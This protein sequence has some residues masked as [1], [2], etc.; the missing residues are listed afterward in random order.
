VEAR[1]LIS[2]IA[3][4][5]GL[6]TDEVQ[7]RLSRGVEQAELRRPDK[8]PAQRFQLIPFGDLKPSSEPAYLIKGLFPRVGLVVV[9]GP[10][11]RGKSFW[12][13]TTMLY[14]ALGW[15]YRGH[16]VFQGAVVYCAF[17]GQDGYG[18]R[19]EA[20][21]QRHLAEAA[22]P[23]P[24]YL[25]AAR[26]SLV[27][28][29]PALISAIKAEAISPAVVVLDTLNRS[30]DGSESDDKDMANYIKAADAI[31][32][33]LGCV[34]VIVHHS[35]V[36][37]TRPRG[38]T[39][40]TGAVDAQIKVMR[41]AAGNIV[42]EVEWMKD[43]PEGEIIV[44]RLEVVDVGTDADGEPI[45]SCVVAPVDGQA[46]PEPARPNKWSKSPLFKALVATI[47]DGRRVQ[48]FGAEGPS[49]NAVALETVRQ[50]FYKSYPAE[51]QP[52]KQKAWIR[53]LKVAA[54]DGLIGTREVDDT[55]LIWLARSPGQPGHLSDVSGHSHPDRPDTPLKGCPVSGVS[56]HGR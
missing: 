3:Q 22:D 47:D 53:A 14:V 15:E 18:K 29:H 19:A 16:K 51:N 20:F 38:H 42:A 26:M 52:A 5:C 46:I 1:D 43:G 50:E 27:K 37:A 25:V 32:E 11:K 21:R 12:V 39:S 35:G 7:R 34:V 30:L 24:F 48:P 40:L 41:D 36:D 55:M 23:V 8:Q 2:E 17:E 6:D 9:W 54:E 45:T 33:E 44:S 4:D 28:D 13:T 56:G 10:P 49:V 31:R